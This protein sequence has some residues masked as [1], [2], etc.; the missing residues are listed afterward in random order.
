MNVSASFYDRHYKG[1][2]SARYY[3]L[4]NRYPFRT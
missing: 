2:E 3:Q 1:K 4:H